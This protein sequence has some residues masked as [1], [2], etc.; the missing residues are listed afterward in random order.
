[1]GFDLMVQI[2]FCIL[3]LTSMFQQ[4]SPAS[5]SGSVLDESTEV[6]VIIDYIEHIFYCYVLNI[7]K[8]NLSIKI[9]CMFLLIAVLWIFAKTLF[10]S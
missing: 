4:K 6:H 10:H 5:S 2:D 9:I 8:I 1:M 7:H 3:C